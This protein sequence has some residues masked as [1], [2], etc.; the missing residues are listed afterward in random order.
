MALFPP[1]QTQR[2]RKL[3]ALRGKDGG[4][5]GKT[6]RDGGARELEAPE[7]VRIEAILPDLSDRRVSARKRSRR[8]FCAE[9]MPPVA[10]GPVHVTNGGQ[11]MDRACDPDPRAWVLPLPSCNR[12]EE[13]R[14][15][16]E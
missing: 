2:R 14:V 6:L 5:R 1:P 11:W 10:T 3:V 4:R 13:R 7:S 16:E 9:R 8:A 15:G 12:S